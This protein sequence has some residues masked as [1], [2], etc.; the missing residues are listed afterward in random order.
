ML[1]GSAAYAAL[2]ARGLGWDV[3]VLTSAAPDF[4]PARD[5]PGVSCF[6]QPASATTRFRN[7]YDAEGNRVQVLQAR[8]ADLDL[9]LVPDEWRDPDALLLCPVAH[10]LHGPIAR[11]FTAEVVG[12][13]AQGWLRA[14][15]EDGTVEAREWHECASELAGV[16]ALVY[17]EQDLPQPAEQARLFLRHV[18]MVL[19]TRGWQGLHLFD[20]QGV[21]D[22]PALPRTEVDPTG[23]GDVFAT[24]FLLR[25]QET[26]DPLEAAAFGACAASCVVEGLG[27][28]RVGDRAE[29]ERR[30]ADRERLLDGDGPDE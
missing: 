20:R 3:A 8:A 9:T 22:V 19:V 23:A 2:C 29:V 4:A 10:E 14:F 18:P 13:T 7:E 17:S 1:G 21:H 30:L 11:S 12:A 27:A 5:L 28:S 26:G 24:G 25:Y 16:H 15:E 6:V